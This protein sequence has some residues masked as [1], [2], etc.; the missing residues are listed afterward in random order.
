MKKYLTNIIIELGYKGN[1]GN[2]ENPYGRFAVVGGNMACFNYKSL[3]LHYSRIS[4]IPLYLYIL[5]SLIPFF[6]IY[7][8]SQRIG[9]D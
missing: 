4:P 5:I 8:Q 6:K 2:R 9:I 7:P 3:S 1:R